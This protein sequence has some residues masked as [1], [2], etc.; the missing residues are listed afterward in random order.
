[1]QPRRAESLKQRNTLALQSHASALVEVSGMGDLTSAIDWARSEGLPLLPFG[2]GS[3][4]VLA[5]D[6]EAL[7]VY[8]ATA[9]IELLGE[10]DT[11]VHLRV[12][13]GVNWHHL[14][15]YCLAQGWYGLENLALIPGQVGAAPIQNIGAYGV[16]FE[17]FVRAV[18]AVGIEDGKVIQLSSSE[19]QFGYRDSIFKRELRDSV[20]ITAVE[21]VLSRLPTTQLKYPALLEELSD[22]GVSNPVP[23]DVFDAVVSVRRRRLPDPA[24]HANAGSFFKNPVISGAHSDQLLKAQPGLPCYE[25]DD[26]SVKIPAAWLIEQAGWKGTREGGVGVHPEHA[27]V[28]VNY[29][30]DSG[31]ELLAFANRI[32][33]SVSQ[34]FGIELEIEPRIY[35]R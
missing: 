25:Q 13:A 33:S 18:H 30:S 9:A 20:V 34:Q 15:G 35:G 31:A 17:R 4:L 22:R 26:G 7:V 3:N 5:G 28:L 8:Q 23:T 19:C 11:E 1:M 14:V 29:A 21:I 12:D 27:L 32:A 10:S 2:E 16:E 6:I 24:V